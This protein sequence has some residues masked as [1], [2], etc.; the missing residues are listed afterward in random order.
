MMRA[1]CGGRRLSPWRDPAKWRSDYDPKARRSRY[2]RNP[3]RRSNARR[4]KRARDL[5]ASCRFQF[6][7][8]GSDCRTR[9]QRVIQSMLSEIG[10]P[11][12][13]VRPKATPSAPACARMRVSPRRPARKLR[14]QEMRCQPGSVRA[15]WVSC[16]ATDRAAA[17]DCRRFQR[18]LRPLTQSDWPVGCSGK[19]S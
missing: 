10:V 14:S 11:L 19:G 17:E 4:Y 2:F 3:A 12:G 16:V 9:S 15:F 8:R 18:R 7:T 13:V 1:P 6:R 5:C